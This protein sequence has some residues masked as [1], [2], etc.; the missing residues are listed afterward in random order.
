LNQAINI[1][2]D[3]P[4]I[5]ITMGQLYLRQSRFE[6]AEYAFNKAI[7]VEQSRDMSERKLRATVGIIISQISQEKLT[8]AMSNVELLRKAIPHH[9]YPIYLH[10]LLLYQTK[11]YELA[12][13]QLLEVQKHLSNHLPTIFLLGACNYALGNYEQANSYLAMFV[14]VIP[15]HIQARKL[16]GASRLKLHQPEL[17]MEVL[18]PITDKDLNDAKLLIMA[19]Q[20][21]AS[22]GDTEIHLK[23]LKKA[24]RLEPGNS[25]IRS[26]L[27]RVY[28]KNGAINEAID[29][30]ESFQPTNIDENR[31]KDLLLIYAYLRQGEYESARNKTNTILAQTPDDPG[32]HTLRG[33]IEL[34]A[35][36]RITAR[37]YY[38]NAIALDENYIPAQISLARLET[39]DGD[40]TEASKLYHRVL[41]SDKNSIAAMFGL[42]QIAEQQG[43]MDLALTWVEQAR[44]AD[45]SAVTPRIVLA[46][47]YLNTGKLD[48]ALEIAKELYHISP[49]KPASLFILGRVQRL[50]GDLEN[51]V[52][53]LEILVAKHPDIVPAYLELANCYSQLKKYQK[54]RDILAVGVELK[55]DFLQLKVAQVQLEVLAEN[56][57]H[58]LHY[59]EKIQQQY[60]DNI[61]G[62]SLAGDIYFREK[63]YIQAQ[64]AYKRALNIQQTAELI[65]K[66]ARAYNAESKLAEATNVLKIG[67]NTF[68]NNIALRT[69]LASNYHQLGEAAQAEKH[70]QY[71]LDQQPENTMVL[72]NLALLY[73]DKDNKQALKYAK[74]AYHLAPQ[75]ITISDTL[76]WLLVEKGEVASGLKLLKYANAN[77][78]DS[79]ITYH[80]AVALVKSGESTEARN[81]LAKLLEKE[82]NF[83]ERE[84][85]RKLLTDLEK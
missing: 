19:G 71:I 46:K 57:N 22:L 7:E 33:G 85:A 49:N 3:N 29:E 15:T 34:L 77:S 76:G 55:P 51:S 72:N 5:W 41:L 61:V 54:A 80:H 17:A 70:Y 74:Q 40:L 39:E 1:S 20:A 47:Y 14:N 75:S 42:A 4:D 65:I 45:L 24:A 23:Y 68:P 28:L 38:L 64:R 9:P 12:R 36:K 13:T 27:A 16:L 81:L 8:E 82:E 2:K 31:K 58:A 73:A 62:F 84:K 6:D 52:K 59:A 53:T 25:S 35:G 69:A 21:A 26:E 11:N 83:K 30:L 67:L 10:A 79:T 78:T 44:K 32:L 50:S 43:E 37:H 63:K 48:K 18:Q 56:N 66:L 60:K